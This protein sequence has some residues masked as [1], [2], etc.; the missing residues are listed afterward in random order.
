MVTVDPEIPVPPINYGGIERI[1]DGLI[2]EYTRQGHRVFLLAHPESKCQSAKEIIPWKG[3]SSENKLD[4][5]KNSLQLLRTVNNLKPDIIHSFSRLLYLWP[6]FL[7]TKVKAVMTYQREVSN[8]TTYYT[9]KLADNKIWF[10]ACGEHITKNLTVNNKFLP[11]HNFT[12]TSYFT[13]DATIPKEH[14][15]YLGRIQD[16]KGTNE[17]IEVA[18]ATNQKLIIAGNIHP[19][20]EAYFKKEVEP[21]FDNPLIEYV[22]L[23]ND[24]QKQYYLQRAKA[25]LF[26]IKWEEPFGIVMAEAMA[27][28]TPVIGFR[29]GSVPEV[30]Q[31]GING[32]IVDNVDEMSNA[33]NRIE[34]IDRKTVR[35]YC[36]KHFS[37]EV[38][39]RQYLAYFEKVLNGI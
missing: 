23:V 27:C 29:R 10:T 20:H 12:D 14:L 2:H 6:A 39:A 17:A 1:A 26:P 25:F 13:D 4:T 9:H 35:D 22:G 34:E 28:G 19:G 30:V 33:V 18:L 7:L 36:V 8:K 11:I 32:F 24:E 15:M 3:K 21:H 16:I 31:E 5:L 38:I 37:R